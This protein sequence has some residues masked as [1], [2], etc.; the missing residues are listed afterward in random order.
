MLAGT[1]TVTQNQIAQPNCRQ[2]ARP[3]WGHSLDRPNRQA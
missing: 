3:G 1:I 2:R